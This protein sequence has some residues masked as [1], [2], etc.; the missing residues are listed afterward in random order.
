MLSESDWSSIVR[1]LGD[2]ADDSELA[3]EGARR[4]SVFESLTDFVTAEAWAWHVVE[5]AG[6]PGDVTPSLEWSMLDGSWNR[7]SV[8]HLPRFCNHVQS[9]PALLASL[10]APERA[11]RVTRV[12]SSPDQPVEALVVSQTLSGTTVGVLSIFRLHSVPFTARDVALARALADNLSWL[13]RVEIVTQRHDGLSPRLRQVLACL[14]EGDGRKQIAYKLK[15]SENTIAAYLKDLY[16]R[17]GVQSK[18][19][20]L[21]KA[22]D[23]TLTARPSRVR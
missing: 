4:R 2:I 8:D 3:D 17:F 15:L 10:A 16:G 9:D 12:Y 22:L 23:N 6:V 21:A 20:L 1:M 19:E 5:T 13:L 7:P 18:A 14:F 11:A